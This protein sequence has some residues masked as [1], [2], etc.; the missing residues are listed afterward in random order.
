MRNFINVDVICCR[1]VSRGTTKDTNNAL[2]SLFGR[3]SFGVRLPQTIGYP[4]GEEFLSF[5]FRFTPKKLLFMIP[6]SVPLHTALF[7]LL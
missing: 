5:V 4:S 6:A 3:A 2:K 1:P 7:V